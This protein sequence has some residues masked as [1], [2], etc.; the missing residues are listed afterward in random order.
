M[1]AATPIDPADLPASIHDFLAA[2]AAHD[3]DA[4]LAHFG[5]DAVVVDDGRKYRGVDGL[6]DFLG[7]AGSEFTYTTE[8]VGASRLD[9]EHWM[10]VH[11]LE[12]D[13]PGGVVDLTYS[14]TLD[15]DRI[16]ELVIAP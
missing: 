4:A 16:T 6:T 15:G 5:D 13:F 14:F 1:T 9:H 12:G 11:H 10:V 8:L 2:H 7:R 3:T